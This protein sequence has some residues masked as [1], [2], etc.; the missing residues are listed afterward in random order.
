MNK[1]LALKEKMD[2]T[3]LVQRL[4]KPYSS[5]N[6][7]SFGVGLKDGGFKKEAATVLKDIIA[8]DYMGAA[9]FEWGAVPSTLSFISI[10]SKEDNLVAGKLTGLNGA[11][12]F[13]LCPTQYKEEVIKRITAIENGTLRLKEP[14]KNRN[15]AGCLE[16]DNGFMFFYDELMFRR[17]CTLF[18]YVVPKEE[19][20]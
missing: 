14:H 4:E 3:F 1:R 9:E 17:V 6:P 5:M 18:G 11:V 15:T 10:Q 19:G 7:Y 12:I 2:K 20:K 13:Y 8:F 16:L